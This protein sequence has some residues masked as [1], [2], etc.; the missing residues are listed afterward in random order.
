MNFAAEQNQAEVLRKSIPELEWMDR[1]LRY[2]AS[3]ER[4][5]DRT[6]AQLERV[7]RVRQGQPV[8]PRLDLN[9]CG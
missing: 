5:F 2:E 3:L 9:I 8:A 7:Q 6:L 1:L 4:N